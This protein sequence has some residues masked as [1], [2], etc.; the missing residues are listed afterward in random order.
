MNLNG[1]VSQAG[2]FDKDLANVM[3]HMIQTFIGTISTILD[4]FEF[5]SPLES[6]RRRTSI[7][8]FEAYTSVPLPLAEL[9]LG[10]NREQ[11]LNGMTTRHH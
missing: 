5:K 4:L 1:I 9:Y 7:L 8:L 3:A 2:F 11:V 10:M 6:F